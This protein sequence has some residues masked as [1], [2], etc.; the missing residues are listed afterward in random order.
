[1]II[2]M[3][4]FNC[5]N[6]P[7]ELAFKPEVADSAWWAG[8]NW[9]IMGTFIIDLGVNLRTTYIDGD[10][11]EEVFDPKKMA[12]HYLKSFRFT[13]DVLSTIPFD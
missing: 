4:L 2:G 8:I 12:L 6:I 3:A 11:G 10:E 13:I 9:G 7:F 1:M 5:F